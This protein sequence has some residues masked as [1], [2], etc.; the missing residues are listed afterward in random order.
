MW[1]YHYKEG[2]GVVVY[3]C[4]DLQCTL[5]PDLTINCND[6]FE[7]CFL[8]LKMNK[9]PIILSEICHAPNKHSY[10]NITLY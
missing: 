2:G 9:T 8:E 10:M 5:R 3:V 7:S 1:T 6:I 4:S